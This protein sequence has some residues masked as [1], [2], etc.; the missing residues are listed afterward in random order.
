MPRS[1]AQ[2]SLSVNSRPTARAITCGTPERFAIQQA[3]RL[4]SSLLVQ[5]M[6]IMTS[7]FLPVIPAFASITMS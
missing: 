1:F 6:S 2:L 5:A 4:T 7:D 3:M